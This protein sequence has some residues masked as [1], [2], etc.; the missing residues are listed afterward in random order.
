MVVREAAAAAAG[1]SRA[2]AGAASTSTSASAS[3]VLARRQPRRA[4]SGTDGGLE[5]ERLL[6]VRGLPP[7]VSRLLE[8]RS[9]GGHGGLGMMHEEEDSDSDD[10]DAVAVEYDWEGGGMHVERAAMPLGRRAV[11]VAAGA[12]PGAAPV[13]IEA[14][15]GG[16][17]EEEEEEHDEHAHDAHPLAA[18]LPPALLRCPPANRTFFFGCFLLSSRLFA[19]VFV[20]LR[21]ASL[22]LPLSHSNLCVCFVWCVSTQAAA[23][24]THAAAGAVAGGHEFHSRAAPHSG[25]PGP[26]CR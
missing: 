3:A 11:V 15:G 8:A 24:T 18:L 26:G 6:G 2:R 7:A 16:E 13:L 17:E 1:A 5:L 21:L 4:T 22:P 19:L 20:R 10:E 14:S 23:R 25:H 12:T 9:F